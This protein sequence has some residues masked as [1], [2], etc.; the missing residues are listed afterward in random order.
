M[1]PV[2][3]GKVPNPLPTSA[4]VH[5]ILRASGKP[6]RRLGPAFG[7][8]EVL[9]VETGGTRLPPILI[10]AG[11]HTPE[12]AG[13][14]AALRLLDELE[15]DRK[16]YV[17]PLRD[18][19]GFNDFDHCLSTLVGRPTTVASHAE[20]VALLGRVGEI[21]W[22]RDDFAIGLVGEVAI[23]SLDTGDEPLGYDLTLA[24]LNGALMGQ[25]SLLPALSGRRFFV[26]SSMPTSEGAGRY[27]RT[28]T[29]FVSPEG[30]TLSVSQFFDRADAPL[31]VA[32]LKA[33][34][35][36]IKPAITFDCHED[37]GRGFYLPA[38]RKPDEPERSEQIVRAMRDAVE[39]TGYPM[40]DFAAFAAKAARYRPY[41]P[42]YHQFSGEPGLFW[43]DGLKRGIGYILVDYVLRYGFAMPTETGAEASL[44]ARA[45]C[46][47]RAV[48][49]GMQAFEETSVP[50]LEQAR[51]PVC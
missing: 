47:V 30:K 34:V 26:P 2:D 18:P 27:G 21:L 12:A 9:C 41:W 19:F 39:A 1:N 49:A 31:E 40:A 48:L 32:C 11:A 45:E 35:D 29:G 15:T 10:T 16:T 33:L 14:V 38:R 51:P 22:D 28:Y 36:E 42:P 17:V 3:S 6:V 8:E 43:T 50:S 25:P 7:G 24:Y 37:G 13:V 20:I 23:V 44:A 4:S 46:H 5:D